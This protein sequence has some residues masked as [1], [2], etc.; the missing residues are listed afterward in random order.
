M[1][2]ESRSFSF[3]FPIVLLFSLVLGLTPLQADTKGK[4][5]GKVVDK[6]NE[7]LIGVN[8][9]LVG[10]TLGSVTDLEGN[11]VI[12]NIPPALYQ[13]RVSSI[14]YSPQVV[15][16]VRISAGQTTT[17]NV[18]LSEQ[19][20]TL[21][22][23]VVKAEKPIVDVRQT[24]S[25]AILGKDQIAVLPVQDLNDIVNL[26]AG[27]VDGHF[28]GG[29]LGEVQYQVDGVS[30][31]NPFDN[32]SSVKLDRSVLQEVQIISGTFDAEYGQAMSGVVNAILKSGSED[33]F[34]WNVELYSGDYINSGKTERFPFI[35]R[36][37]P[38]AIQSYQI[39]LSGPTGL[40]KTTFLVGGRYFNNAGC[41]FGERRFV[42]GDVN[43]FQSY[44]FHPTGDGKQVSMGDA[45]EL[46][47][48][49]K[50]SNRSLAG[51]Q[52]G[53]Q[54]IGNVI[55][56]QFYSH[57]FRFNPDGAKK[58]RSVSL[59]HGIDATH[60]LSNTLFYTVSLRQNYYR[61]TDFVYEDLFDPRYVQYGFPKGD[62]NYEVGAYVQGVDLSRFKQETSS[63]ILKA[64]LTNQIQR[65]HLLK[66]G[67]EFQISKIIFGP[68]GSL[69]PTTV[70]GVQVLVPIIDS[71]DY[72]G[73]R[74]YHPLMGSAFI[75]D[76]IE[77]ED[78][79]VRIGGRLEYFNARSE[80]PGDLQNP[81]NAISGAPTSN[82]RPINPKMIFAPRLG[83]SYPITD[84]GSI[85]FSYGHF[86][87][88]PGLGQLFSNSDYTILK[89][90]QAGSI[91]FGVMGNP[92]L[93]PEFTT[94]YEVGV[95]SQLSSSLG[96]DFSI[97]YKDI[98]DL[99]GVE[100]VSTYTAAEYARL[101]NVDFGEVE[102]FTLAID[103]RSGELLSA[104][105]DYS[106]Q[107][108]TGNS[109]DPR[110]TATRAA[111]GED[112][113]PRKAPLAWD[114]RHT[115]NANLIISERENYSITALA[116]F[117]SGQPYTPTVL[118][119]LGA[120]L[121]TNSGRKATFLVADLRAEKSL[122]IF[123]V[124]CSLFLRVFNLFNTHT[125]NGFVFT[126]TGSPDYTLNVA[127]NAS[128]LLDPS[129]YYPPRRIELGFSM[130]SISR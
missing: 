111:G 91:S 126:D 96:F 113:R 58:Q 45:E 130:N 50:I 56:S 108:T 103:Y 53:Y 74:S 7:P 129:R 13:V 5:A 36:I 82:L 100:F 101:T 27:V 68:P 121:E 125:V 105:V 61:Y 119:R 95:K 20:V 42:P 24:S 90:L 107:I 104:S 114:Q 44:R 33:A 81:A 80:L 89:D 67:A 112:P 99:L 63:W 15:S 64:S 18:T 92:N 22:E 88:M 11:Y 2:S 3:Q 47:G 59:S 83:I 73:L 19:A 128:L 14:G 123:G 122:D 1:R 8:I 57:A 75:Q 78:F 109:S 10:T 38:L 70:N 23:V 21:E 76:R 87:Q 93:K 51:I 26:Q 29:R 9:L 31:N 127:G 79:L 86:Y 46:S 52:L 69:V 17:I 39:S 118:S 98:R 37:D 25:V 4:L 48:Q 97:Y 71:P 54:A 102:G 60:S 16:E 49:L 110:E 30:V 34:E 6:K 116:R 40:E 124:R 41:L 65:Y 106:Y 43:D 55:K 28:R 77:L 12:L 32:S 117:G 120:N 115:L 66:A 84:Q 35:N 94:Q 85:F 62:R 72:P